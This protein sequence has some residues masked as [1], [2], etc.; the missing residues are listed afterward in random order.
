MLYWL[1]VCILVSFWRE[2]EIFEMVSGVSFRT[3]EFCGVDISGFLIL[4]LRL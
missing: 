3:R 2:I 4:E 1:L